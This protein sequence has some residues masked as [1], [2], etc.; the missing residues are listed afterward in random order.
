MLINTILSATI[1]YHSF[2]Y[3]SYIAIYAQMR[4]LKVL[5]TQ[6][7]TKSM[8]FPQYYFRMLALCLALLYKLAS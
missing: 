8:L 2:A 6:I 3:V 4:Q 7:F 5:R 1:S